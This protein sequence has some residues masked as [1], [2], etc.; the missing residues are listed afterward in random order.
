MGRQEIPNFVVAN[1]P[2]VQCAVSLPAF[3]FVLTMPSLDTLQRPF[4]VLQGKK[5]KIPDR[6]TA[7][8]KGKHFRFARGRAEAYSAEL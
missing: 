6:L 8:Y 7:D 5:N 2:Q 3:T 1:I 4:C